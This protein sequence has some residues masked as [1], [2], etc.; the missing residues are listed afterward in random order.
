MKWRRKIA[1]GRTQWCSYGMAALACV[2]MAGAGF[3]PSLQ[4]QDEP[5]RR[6]ADQPRTQPQEK[7]PDRAERPRA[8]RGDRP[9]TTPAREDRAERSNAADRG[10]QNRDGNWL[11]VWVEPTP[12]NT[13]VRVMSVHPQSPA[14][15]AGLRAGDYLLQLNGKKIEDANQVT[16]MVRDAEPGAQSQIT[17][18]RN[19]REQMLNVSF[20]ARPDDRADGQ[21]SNREPQAW[22]GV[23]LGESEEARG[24]MVTNVFP[25]GPAARAGLRGGDVITRINDQEITN[26]E[27]V[28]NAVGAMKAGSEAKLTVQRRGEE[29]MLTARLADRG[30]FLA[31]EYFDKGQDSSGPF[32]D[33]DDAFSGIPDHAIMLEQQR[34]ICLQH[35]RIEDLVQQVLDEV[36]TLRSEV[37]AMKKNS[38]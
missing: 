27:D 1:N 20:A 29:V 8:N 4:G 22:L 10:A 37:E 36:K 19:G 15:R 34:H 12:G 23:G 35:Q 13:G 6:N 26:S 38:R 17:I 7:T 25:S 33:F 24:A 18:W 11:G 21:S 5:A 28:I 3:G 30:D 31:R 9:A 32:D 14:G 16:D 2:I